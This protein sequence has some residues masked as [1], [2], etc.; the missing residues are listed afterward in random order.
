M[1]ETRCDPRYTPQL[2]IDRFHSPRKMAEEWWDCDAAKRRDG[3]RG[4]DQLKSRPVCASH[5]GTIIT[6]KDG[7]KWTARNSRTTERLQMV[8]FDRDKFVSVGWKGIIVTSSNGTRW[9]L[10][11]SGISDRLDGIFYRDGQFVASITNRAA[12]VSADGKRWTEPELPRQRS[13]YD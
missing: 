5:E 8:A 6:S 13:A 1:T 12:R 3:S 11:S 10:R 4:G 2:P 9:K 7:M